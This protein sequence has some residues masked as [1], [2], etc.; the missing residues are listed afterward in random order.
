MALGRQDVITS[1]LK[2]GI[3][4]KKRD[5]ILDKW[6]RRSF[7]TSLI[8]FYA[9]VRDEEG[10]PIDTANLIHSVGVPGPIPASKHPLAAL[11]SSAD[12]IGPLTGKGVGKGGAGK[13]IKKKGSGYTLTAHVGMVYARHVLDDGDSPFIQEPLARLGP[14]IKE[15]FDLG[16]AR[17]VDEMEGSI[18][19]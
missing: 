9:D 8:G 10:F 5:R 13:H 11:P 16:I 15:N 4:A 18:S 14:V 6:I 2:M 19:G 3:H 7:Q 12:A 17:A 1:A